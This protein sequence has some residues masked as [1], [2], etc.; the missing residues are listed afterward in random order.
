MSARKPCTGVGNGGWINVRASNN[1]RSLSTVADVRMDPSS[2]SKAT[3]SAA[4]ASHSSHINHLA[5]M[6]IYISQRQ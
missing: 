3:D 6:I 1:V 4:W 5:D 2:D